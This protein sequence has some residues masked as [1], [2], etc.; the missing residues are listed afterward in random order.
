MN[1]LRICLVMPVFNEAEV[2]IEHVKSVLENCG[3]YLEKINIIDDCS[4]DDT[5]TRLEIFKGNIK[6]KV[7]KNKINLGHGRTVLKGMKE[8]LG[9][10][11]AIITVDGDGN[12]DT[13]RLL[14][15]I[16]CLN[17][18]R[19]YI[20]GVR[21]KREEAVYRKIVTLATRCVVF[22]KTRNFPKDANT[23]IRGYKSDLL[24]EFLSDM[25]DTTEVPNLL[26]SII[27]RKKS[28]EII[29][30][31]IDTTIRARTHQ[32]GTTWQ[33][34]MKHIP[35]KKFLKFIFKASKEVLRFS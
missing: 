14:E 30:L 8:N 6:I 33:S 11:D 1:R 27:A 18:N 2:V 28:V 32:F 13:K 15:I 4:T 31:N 20:E 7:T 9:N 22:F 19:R 25:P 35:S 21:V 3:D 17:E 34:K 12:Y 23:P 16:D 5:L 24:F 29:E 10:S 26:I